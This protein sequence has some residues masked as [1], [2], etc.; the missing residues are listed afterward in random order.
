MFRAIKSVSYV[1]F[2]LTCIA[3]LLVGIACTC[4]SV[5]QVIG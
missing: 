1:A 3:A 5:S 4:F 2:E